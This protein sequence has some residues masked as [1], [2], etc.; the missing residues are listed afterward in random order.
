MSP[1]RAL[2]ELNQNSSKILEMCVASSTQVVWR[3][4]AVQVFAK[5]LGWSFKNPPLGPEVPLG[6]SLFF[7][8]LLVQK[9]GSK[10]EHPPTSWAGVQATGEGDR[11]GS[12]LW[13]FIEPAERETRRASCAETCTQMRSPL[14]PVPPA[15]QL[16]PPRNHLWRNDGE[17]TAKLWR[18]YGEIMAKLGRNDGEIM[19][20]LWRNYGEIMAKL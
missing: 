12:S 1:P 11:E 14:P 9:R 16:R 20:K 10:T 15:T 5:A 2:P 19:A 17:I 18:N 13:G 6:I 7:V 8:I 3:L 4:G